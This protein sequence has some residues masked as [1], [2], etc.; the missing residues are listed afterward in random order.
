M[1]KLFGS[2]R[3]WQY[4][5]SQGRS[6]ESVGFRFGGGWGVGVTPTGGSGGYLVSRG[7][8]YITILLFL[9]GYR[10]VTMDV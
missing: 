9:I 6:Q 1:N 8:K 10:F 7:C 2:V 3:C 5:Y 4:R